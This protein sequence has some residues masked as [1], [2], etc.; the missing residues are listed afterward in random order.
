MKKELETQKKMN[1]RIQD[2]NDRERLK[3]EED[4]I[5]EKNANKTNFLERMNNKRNTQQ[6]SPNNMLS[7]KQVRTVGFPRNQSASRN[8]NLGR[9]LNATA[10]NPT[11]TSNFGTNQRVPSATRNNFN[12]TTLSVNRGDESAD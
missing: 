9:N 7:P 4:F 5:R 1:I 6:Q 11:N 10:R 8:N 3:M 2:K 12:T